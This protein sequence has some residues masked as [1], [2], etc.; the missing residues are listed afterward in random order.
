MIAFPTTNAFRQSFRCK[1]TQLLKNQLQP[2]RTFNRKEEKKERKGKR[3]KKAV[4]SCVVIWLLAG[5]TRIYEE[6]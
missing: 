2:E 3:E 6:T 1:I 4:Y 5:Y